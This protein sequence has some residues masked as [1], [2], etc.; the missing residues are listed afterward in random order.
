M[1]I[2]SR[3]CKKN[4]FTKLKIISVLKEFSHDNNLSGVIKILANKIIAEKQQ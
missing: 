3:I 4:L 2:L 1:D